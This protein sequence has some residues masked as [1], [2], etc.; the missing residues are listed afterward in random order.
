MDAMRMS[1]ASSVHITASYRIRYCSV[2]LKRRGPGFKEQRAN[3][4]KKVRKSLVILCFTEFIPFF[5]RE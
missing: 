4:R 3:H 2:L 5:Y 1:R